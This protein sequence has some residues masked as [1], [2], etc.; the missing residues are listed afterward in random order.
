MTLCVLA[1]ALVVGACGAN[2]E[3]SQRGKTAEAAPTT[4]STAGGVTPTTTGSEAPAFAEGDADAVLDYR[5]VDYH[6]EGPIKVQ[7]HKIYFKAANTGS[8]DH[9]LEVLD[10][11]GDPLGEVEAMPPGDEGSA[12]MELEPGT[13]TLQCILETKDGQVHRDLGMVMDLEVS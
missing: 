2:A 10:A 8:E 11:N 13:Y 4:S 7:G 5:L 3:L 1:G 12:A 6:F 9:E